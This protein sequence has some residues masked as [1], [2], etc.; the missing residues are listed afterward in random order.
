MSLAGFMIMKVSKKRKR[1]P[2][3]TSLK[4]KKRGA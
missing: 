1:A 3:K 4:P 2:A